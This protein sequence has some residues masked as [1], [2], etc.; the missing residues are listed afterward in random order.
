MDVSR[1]TQLSF[2]GFHAWFDWSDHHA[3]CNFGR[4][5]HWKSARYPRDWQV[6]TVFRALAVVAAG[7]RAWLQ[8]TGKWSDL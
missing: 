5:W 6:E 4:G 2:M 8:A 3:S 1:V 7:R